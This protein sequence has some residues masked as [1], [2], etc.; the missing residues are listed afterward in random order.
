MA[1][2]WY[3]FYPADYA[4]DTGHLTL[5]EHG[6]YRVLMDHYYSRGGPLSANVERLLR[7]CR[8]NAQAEKDAVRFVLEEFFTAQDEM[9]RHPRIDAEIAKAADITAKC[10]VAGR[11]SALQRQRKLEGAATEGA[12]A[13]QP[14][15][16]HS[17]SQAQSQKSLDEAFAQFWA[18]YPRREARGAARSA[19]VRA[20][21]GIAP[22]TLIG[23]AAGYAARREG[24]DR[25]FTKLAAT[26]LNQECW[27]DEA[28]S[29]QV[30]EAGLRA[31][32]DGRAGVLV[33]QIGAAMFQAY[34]G[35]ADFC[36]GPPVR[37]RVGK[38]H[39]RD[40]MQRKF[41]AALKR[42]YGEYIL[43]VRS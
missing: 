40:L 29:T 22:Q 13:E 17:P 16:S 31:M 21:E 38:A 26:W 37:V 10:A 43:E 4:R 9:F 39:L 7:V 15:Q 1:R 2:P 23:A 6:A 41:G 36:A 12:T 20:A 8:A 5:I 25:R 11:A 35:G 33:D 3:S 19:F 18:A 32:W 27:L 42:A 34:F 30:D 24:Q 28:H 14:S